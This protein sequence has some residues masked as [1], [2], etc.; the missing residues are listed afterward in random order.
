MNFS[1]ESLS[2]SPVFEPLDSPGPVGKEHR[3][4]STEVTA[5]TRPARASAA[6]VVP[7]ADS[8]TSFEEVTLSSFG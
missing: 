4:E 7:H 6:V 8:G 1:I 3:T 2:A 5:A